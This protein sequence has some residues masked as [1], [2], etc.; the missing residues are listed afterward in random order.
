MCGIAGYIG[1]RNALPFLIDVLGR[2]EYRG[3]DSAGIAF[4]NGKGIEVFRAEGRMENLQWM[5]TTPL[6]DARLGLAH[7]GWMTRSETFA[8]YGHPRSFKGTAVVYN[9]I[10][11]NFDELKSFFFAGKHEY[12]T[13]GQIIPLMVSH[14]THKGLSP[15]ELVK[16]IT[17]VL[18]GT[19][20]L[21]VMCESFPGTL[22][23]VK[24]GNP[25]AVAL[26]DGE[27]FFASDVPALLPYSKKFI[28]LKDRQMCILRQD[29]LQ[30]I[31]MD[32]LETIRVKDEVRELDWTGTVAEKEGYDHFMLKEIYDQPKAIMDTLSE[33]MDDPQKL[34]DEFGIGDM[35][36]R[37]RRLHI[38]GCGTSYHAGLVGRYIIE[39]FARIPAITDMASEYRYMNPVVSKGTLFVA[40]T[41]S[42][43]TADTIAA[44]LE[45][46]EKGAHVFT[47]CNTVGS[48]AARESDSVLYT[49]AGPEIGEASTKTF[50]AQLAALSFLGIAL[51]TKKGRLT[52]L[53]IETL[54]SMLM[55]LPCLIRKAL[56]TDAATIKIAKKL[57]HAKEIFYLGR[58]INY[59]IALEGALKMKEVAHIHAEGYPAGEMKHGPIALIEE[60]TP[61]VVI[62]PLD[63]LYEKVLSNI[64]EVM[65]KGGRIV[66]ITDAPAALTGKVEDV[67]IVPPAHPALTPFVSVVPLQLL[68]YHIAVLRGCSVDQPRTRMEP[69]TV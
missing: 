54:K 53:E 11:E 59:P 9:G 43:E 38:V 36:K 45:A 48:T 37:L 67:I 55:D 19:Y 41:E 51:A 65:A 22:F 15:E 25:L 31:G 64:E 8:Q 57:V 47:I 42:G 30:L 4:Q 62:A 58:G 63:G 46:K 29:G 7:A 44:L 5:L 60:G 13:D 18:K 1:K 28:F 66:A 61:V 14:Y 68:A 34:L 23:A 17:S 49:R 3:Y 6:P 39:K 40:L 69:A 56:R 12:V 32:S 33:W 24:C 27:Y 26:G 52:P 16:K 10:I 20:A 21:G 35:I 2:L 50:A